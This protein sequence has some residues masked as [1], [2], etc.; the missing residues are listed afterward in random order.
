MLEPQGRLHSTA[1]VLERELAEITGADVSRVE[2]IQTLWGGYG[3]LVRAHL[4]GGQ[5]PSV[6]VKWI[7]PPRGGATSDASHARKRRSYAVETAFYRAFAPRCDATCR[8]ARLLGDRVTDDQWILVLEDLDAAGYDRRHHD[9]RGGELDACLRWLAAFHAR[10]LG[11]APDGLWQVG[12]YWHLGTRMEELE[13]TRDEALRERAPVVDRALN[14]ARFQTLVHG[15]AKPDNFCFS[16][17]GERV[18]AVDFQY[19]GGGCG[20][21]DV[22]YLLHGAGGGVEERGL[23]T[24]FTSL[25]EALAE[26]VD[27]DALEREWRDL[28]P[29]AREDFRRFLAGWRRR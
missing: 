28:Y 6:M 15:D 26:G 25:R 17:N 8:V 16:Q 18:A 19:V 24:Y 10:F 11:Q 12:T 13:A 29:L 9:P 7:R 27:G 1:D 2:R 21:K 4:V 23:A 5:S 20:I 14:T 3:E 22:A